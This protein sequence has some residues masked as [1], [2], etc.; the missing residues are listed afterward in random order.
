VLVKV[1]H[2][3]VWALLVGCIV[4]MP[5]SALS[6]HF[7]VA[8]SLGGIVLAEVLVLAVNRMRCPL[9]DVA[10]RFTEKRADN[11]DIYLPLWVA[12]N[13]KRLFGTLFVVGGLV[14]AWAF[15]R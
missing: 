9:T 8:A 5:V 4:G 10:A 3:V 2:T 7:T 6:G 11:F 1:L 12:T 14:S 13:N 15:W